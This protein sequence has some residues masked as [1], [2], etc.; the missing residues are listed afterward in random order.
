MIDDSYFQ[1][2]S[3][4]FRYESRKFKETQRVSHERLQFSSRLNF[5]CQYIIR[6]DSGTNLEF[7]IS[8]VNSDLEFQNLKL[9]SEFS[10]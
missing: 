7:K 6:S 3:D 10:R 9:N 1:L 2:T 4:H 5:T 8:F